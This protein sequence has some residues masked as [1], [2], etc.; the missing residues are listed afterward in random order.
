MKQD[1]KRH[2]YKCGFCG[3]ADGYEELERYLER[4]KYHFANCS[5]NPDN[6]NCYTCKF[7]IKKKGD[8]DEDSHASECYCKKLLELDFVDADI[9]EDNGCS[10]WEVK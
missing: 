9:W 8:V 6:H 10:L 2:V 5:K 7:M 3:Y 4:L 1:D